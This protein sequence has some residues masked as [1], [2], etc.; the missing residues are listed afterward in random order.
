MS[1][2]GFVFKPEV[3]SE[4]RAECYYC[5]YGLD[6]WEVTDDPHQEHQKRRPDCIFFHPTKWQPE[7]KKTKN[8]KK[9]RIEPVKVDVKDA[10][11]DTD[12]ENVNETIV[13]NEM[14]VCCI[15]LV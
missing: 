3:D 1:E 11:E 12:K 2:A 10:I 7:P 5:A 8:I 4:D 6:G 15:V 14:A 9:R 13:M